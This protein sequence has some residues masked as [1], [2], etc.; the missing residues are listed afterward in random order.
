MVG[1]KP[2][3]HRKRQAG[4]KAKKKQAKKDVSLMIRPFGHSSS[5]GFLFDAKRD[6]RVY[7]ER[8]FQE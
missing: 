6:V 5:I 4:G 2:K 1:D 7:V 8:V 3:A